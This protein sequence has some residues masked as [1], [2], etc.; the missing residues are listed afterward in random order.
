MSTVPESESQPSMTRL[1][2]AMELLPGQ[3]SLST[4]SLP[5][6]GFLARISAGLGKGLPWRT[7]TEH[8]GP[9]VFVSMELA[10]VDTPSSMPSRG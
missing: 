9:V 10:D 1:R 2:E 4:T 7:L 8:H 5:A 3:A 6:R